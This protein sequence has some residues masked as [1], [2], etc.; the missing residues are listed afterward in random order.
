M[1]TGIL[2]KLH[3]NGST[4]CPA[5]IFSHCINISKRSWQLAGI[6]AIMFWGVLALG[7]QLISLL[8]FTRDTR[9]AWI[10]TLSPK[11]GYKE[12]KIHGIKSCSLLNFLCWYLLAE[13]QFWYSN[14]CTL[15]SWCLPIIQNFLYTKL[16]VMKAIFW[17]PSNSWK[18][19][20]KKWPAD[21]SIKK[22]KFSWAGDSYRSQLEPPQI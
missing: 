4:P 14:N 21:L 8:K 11:M 17:L 19:S 6:N 9:K 3:S 2:K 10:V 13:Q 22:D 5:P 1:R 7:N 20:K 15:D 16:E 18:D 12:F